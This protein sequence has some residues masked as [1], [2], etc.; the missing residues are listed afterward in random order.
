MFSSKTTVT[1]GK[2]GAKL[3]KSIDDL[4]DK[5]SELLDAGMKVVDE[6]FKEADTSDN[7][8]VSTTIRVRLTPEQ[9]E[10]LKAGAVLGFKA[11]G[12]TITLEVRGK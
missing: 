6:A 2:I 7:V 3:S 8:R 4:M 1:T 5:G 9:I 12:T 11:E 10:S